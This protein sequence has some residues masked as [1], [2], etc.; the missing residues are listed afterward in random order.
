[1]VLTTF[2]NSTEAIASVDNSK[3]NGCGEIYQEAF[4]FRSFT[5]AVRCQML[6]DVPVTHVYIYNPAAEPERSAKLRCTLLEQREE[7][8]TPEQ[9]SDNPEPAPDPDTPQL[10]S[11]ELPSVPS[12][13]HRRGTTPNATGWGNVLFAPNIDVQVH[14]SSTYFLKVV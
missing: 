10:P 9:E 8:E 14:S 2:T 12:T 13:P 5:E 11:H 1:M 3:R 7:V 4:A 6:N